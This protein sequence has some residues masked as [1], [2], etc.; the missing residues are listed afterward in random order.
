MDVYYKNSLESNDFFPKDSSENKLEKEI[1]MTQ[2]HIQTYLLLNVIN[3]E[4]FI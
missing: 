2:E 1:L 3:P 4:H